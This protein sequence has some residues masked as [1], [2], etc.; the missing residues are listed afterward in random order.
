MARFT[1]TLSQ[2]ALENLKLSQE[3]L[4]NK[5]GGSRITQGFAMGYALKLLA[6]TLQKEKEENK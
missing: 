2:E 4:K 3:L 6:E 1:I 5:L